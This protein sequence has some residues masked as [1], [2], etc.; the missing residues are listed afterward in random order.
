MYCYHCHKLYENSG[1]KLVY[2]SGN[3]NCGVL[4]Y[5]KKCFEEVAGEY[6]M[7]EDSY[8]K[9]DNLSWQCSVC[10]IKGNDVRNDE[11]AI[12][13]SDKERKDYYID[14]CIPCFEITAGAKLLK[15]LKKNILE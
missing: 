12:I 8:Y 7:L 5:H 13:I 11:G 2:Y 9:C 6:Y 3:N 10:S 15:Q 4:Y 14:F 1:R